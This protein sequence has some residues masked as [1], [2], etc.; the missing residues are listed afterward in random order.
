[1]TNAQIR[2]W[3]LAQVEVI[4]KQDQARAEARVT[5][6]ARAR[7]AHEERQ[8]ARLQARKLMPNQQEVALLEARDLARYGS[9]DGPDF[10]LLLNQ[11]LATGLPSEEA[12]LRIIES[13]RR[14][15]STT[16]Q[17]FAP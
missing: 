9:S 5:L 6:E 4:A 16:N 14:T 10:N 1:M 17:R 2:T 8:A 7:L 3:Y 13:A 15:D 12:Y 11:Q